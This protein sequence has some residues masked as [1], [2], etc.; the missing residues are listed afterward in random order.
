MAMGNE[1]TLDKPKIS[2][3]GPAGL[4]RNYNI[5]D[6]EGPETLGIPDVSLCLS[7]SI[8]SAEPPDKPEMRSPA[9]ANGR[10]KSQA[11]FNTKN[12]TGADEYSQPETALAAAMRSAMARKAVR[13]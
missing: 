10:A 6:L 9:A 5:N 2:L 12:S 1:A 13:A 11:N 4:R 7:Q 3:V 8:V